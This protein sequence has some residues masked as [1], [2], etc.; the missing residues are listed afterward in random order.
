MW[1]TLT[2]APIDVLPVPK[3]GRPRLVPLVMV[4]PTRETVQRAKRGEVIWGGVSFHRLNQNITGFGSS[5]SVTVANRP[6][7]ALTARQ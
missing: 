7:H 1:L 2:F 3:G 5:E 6:L 4:L